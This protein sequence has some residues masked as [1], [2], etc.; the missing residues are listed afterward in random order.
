MPQRRGIQGREQCEMCVGSMRGW[1]GR[2][3]YTLS[4]A[5][6]GDA[7]EDSEKRNWEREHIWNVNKEDNLNFLRIFIYGYTVKETFRV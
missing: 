2:P 5:G 1:V 6:V 4:D 7:M 3:G